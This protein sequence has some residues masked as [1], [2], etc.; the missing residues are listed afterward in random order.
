MTHVNGVASC[1]R[2]C[3]APAFPAMLSTNMPIVIRLG[4]ACGLIITSGCIPLSLNGIS[5][6]GHFCEQTPF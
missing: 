6:A 5:M 2:P 1:A 4:K 3:I